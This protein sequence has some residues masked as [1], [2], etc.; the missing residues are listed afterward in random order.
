MG[1]MLHVSL[2]ACGITDLV[3]SF[4][5]LKLGGLSK[6][7]IHIHLEVNIVATVEEAVHNFF[8]VDYETF[9]HV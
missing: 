1:E 2:N 8:Y 5:S 9:E 6:V 3:T 4:V 7:T